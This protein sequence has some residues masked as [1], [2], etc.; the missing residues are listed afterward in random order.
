MMRARKTPGN[1]LT[2]EMNL[3]DKGVLLGDLNLPLFLELSTASAAVAGAATDVGEKR[4]GETSKHTGR[5]E[6]KQAGRQAG[7]TFVL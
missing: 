2:K 3:T 6:R 4:V 5:H 1:G 7:S